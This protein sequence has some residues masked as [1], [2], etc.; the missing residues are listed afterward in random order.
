MC[1]ASRSDLDNNLIKL[2]LKLPARSQNIKHYIKNNLKISLLKKFKTP[3][4]LERYV[5]SLPKTAK[6]R[7]ILDKL[8]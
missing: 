1:A 4:D 6:S 7:D 2:S 5:A 8:L 3:E